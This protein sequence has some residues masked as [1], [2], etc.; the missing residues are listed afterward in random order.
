[1]TALEVVYY[2]LGAAGLFMF[3]SIT[4]VVL[5]YVERKFLGRLQ[6]R[7][8]P[9]RVGPHGILQ[10]VADTIKLVIK[11]DMVYMKYLK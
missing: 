8:G 5:T 10:P 6:Q 7:M 9:M 4:V 2:A 3:L 11:E 1:M